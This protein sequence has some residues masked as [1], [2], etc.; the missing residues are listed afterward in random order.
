MR[1]KLLRS[2][3]GTALVL[4]VFL[5]SVIG[6]YVLHITSPRTAAAPADYISLTISQPPIVGQEVTISLNAVHTSTETTA[7]YGISLPAYFSIQSG[8]PN[9][10]SLLSVDSGMQQVVWEL[11]PT[12]GV[13]ESV[14][15]QVVPGHTSNGYDLITGSVGDADGHPDNEVV[16]SLWVK[17]AT[18]SSESSVTDT[19]PLLDV[20]VPPMFSILENEV[21]VPATLTSSDLRIQ[22]PLEVELKFL[23]QPVAGH[24]VTV[25]LELRD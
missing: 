1:R 9:T 23:T 13:T 7:A 17:V 5:I 20:A 2:T 24:A 21:P 22:K 16:S 12:T 4:I 11:A 3:S 8:E 14:H 10:Y 18:S 19:A 15:I 6:T 25:T